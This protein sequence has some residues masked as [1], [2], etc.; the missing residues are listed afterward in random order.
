M[1]KLPVAMK[2]VVWAVGLVA[3]GAILLAA[4]A[5][6]LL[7][8]D[9]G[10]DLSQNTARTGPEHAD[11]LLRDVQTTASPATIV[12]A[13]ESFVRH[14]SSSEIASRETAGDGAK[15]LHLVCTTRLL[16]FRDDVT[17]EL[18]GEGP[19]RI[20]ISSASRVG[21]SDFGQNP[22]NIRELTGWLRER[23]PTRHKDRD[24]FITR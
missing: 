22:R 19:T 23:L 17:V 9:W 21:K 7:V 11:P 12:E 14:N 10:R 16:R 6:I 8:D 24:G 2:R 4:V 15:R 1:R 3:G 5:V 13:I 20:S 18:A